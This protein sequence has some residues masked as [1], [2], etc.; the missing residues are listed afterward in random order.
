[1]IVIEH[2]HGIATRYGHLSEFAVVEG[3]RVKRG[4]VIGYVGM[5]GRS[6]GPHLH[7]EVWVHDAPVNPY[8]Y[9]RGSNGR[10]RSASGA[11]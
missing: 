8:T 10:V 3:Q 9:L 6:T 4:E 2:G 1:M 7:Y 11:D 5:S